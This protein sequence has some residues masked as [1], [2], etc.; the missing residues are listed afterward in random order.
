MLLLHPGKGH[1]IKMARTI[2]PVKTKSYIQVIDQLD[3]IHYVSIETWNKM[4]PSERSQFETI[5]HFELPV[6]G[7]GVATGI[8]AFIR[9]FIR[10]NFQEEAA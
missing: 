5:E 1:I 3:R 10:N 4:L 8:E 2:A 7:S 9:D 6:K